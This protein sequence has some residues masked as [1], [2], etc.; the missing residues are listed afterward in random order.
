MAKVSISICKGKGSLRHNN[1]EFVTENVDRD[2]IKDNVTYVC[3]PL[4]VAYEKCFGHAI[5]EYNERQT[6]SDRKISGVKGYMEQIRNSG[7]GEKLFYEN[8][9]QVGN[10]QDSLVGTPQGDL[11]RDVL[12]EYMRD[13]QRR[14]PNLYVF[15]AVLHL[16]EKT[17]HLHIDYIP[18]A[19]GYKK[20]LSVR[21]SLDRALGEQG[22]EGKSNKYECR[23]IAWQRAEKDHIQEVMRSHGLERTADRGLDREHMTVEQYKAVT[24]A[25][26]NEV[27]Q[28]PKQIETAP[29]MFNRTRVTVSKEDLE[30]LEQRAKLSMEHEKATRQLVADMKQD[31]A[32]GKAF[33]EDRKAE[34]LRLEERAEETLERARAVQRKAEAEMEK[35]HELYGE[36][37]ALNVAYDDLCVK[38]RELREKITYLEQE[39]GSLRMHIASLKD[40][41][42]QRVKEAVAPLV[43]QNE[44]FKRQISDL[45][46]RLQGLAQSFAN[47]VKAVGVLVHKEAWKAPLDREQIGLIEATRKYARK[48]L[49]NDL[50]GIDNALADEL[51]RELD[52][53]FSI[54]SGIASFMPEEKHKAKNYDDLEH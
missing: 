27:K 29:M 31:R 18:L 23:T 11:C 16:D 22:I 49:Q 48:W 32:D 53:E 17:P 1:R 21:N 44:D 33:V 37:L 52:T 3:E 40:S 15:N 28:M 2:R 26:H 43:A 46:E 8:I 30:R 36:Q 10:M 4:E 51:G 9:V 7:N 34:A 35:Y 24:R 12:D 25:I 19:H 13:F 5:A 41:I 39:N 42:E 54:S 6:R 14:N 38:N 47:T 50:K 20:G 45:T